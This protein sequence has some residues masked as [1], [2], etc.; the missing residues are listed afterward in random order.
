M[1]KGD[2]GAGL[3]WLVCV[4]IGYVI[5]IVPGVVLHLI[6]IFTAAPGSRESNLA[7]GGG[8]YIQ[9]NV[10]GNTVK[11]C[12]SCGTRNRREDYICMGCS[13]PLP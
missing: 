2:V 7:G 9:T 5:F 4:A 6:C 12:P 10:S 11:V 8:S 3:L 13:N 1:Y